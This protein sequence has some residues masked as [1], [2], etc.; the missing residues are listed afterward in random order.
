MM[1]FPSLAL[2]LTHPPSAVFASAKGRTFCNSP[3]M[4]HCSLPS[5]FVPMEYLCKVPVSSHPPILIWKS[6]ASHSKTQARTWG[7]FPVTPSSVSSQ[8]KMDPSG[9]PGYSVHSSANITPMVN[10]CS[11]LNYIPLGKKMNPICRLST[12][13]LSTVLLS[14]TNYNLKT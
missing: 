13:M 4:S 8:S 7:I 9:F 1:L 11:L 10:L 5:A 6:T 14:L 12:A 2:W 3:L